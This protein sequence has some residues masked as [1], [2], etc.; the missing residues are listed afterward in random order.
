[1]L[2][3]HRSRALCILAICMTAT[4]WTPTSPAAPV[5]QQDSPNVV[6]IWGDDMSGRVTSAPTRWV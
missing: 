1:M 5:Q 2:S 3:Q 6:I 4:A